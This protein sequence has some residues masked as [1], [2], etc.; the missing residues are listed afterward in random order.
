MEILRKPRRPGNKPHHPAFAPSPTLVPATIRPSWVHRG[1]D[2]IDL[3]QGWPTPLGGHLPPLAGHGYDARPTVVIVV[4]D[5]AGIL[6]SVSRLLACH[7]I[8]S[9]RSRRPWRCSRATA[10]RRQPA[11]CST[12]TSR[13][14]RESSCSAGLRRRDRSAP[15]IFM[16]ADDDKAT[17]N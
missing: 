5:N 3:D 8:E 11:F 1:L 14:F 2:S 12:S 9:R 10:C 15:S 16:T 6:K 13:K 7:G 17:R 4:D